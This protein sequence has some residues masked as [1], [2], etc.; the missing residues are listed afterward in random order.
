MITV[1]YDTSSGKILFP[2]SGSPA[3]GT[4]DASFVERFTAQVNDDLNTPRAL[5]V[6]WDLARSDLDE[7]DRKA[8]L[9]HFDDV[10]GLRLAAWAPVEEV[11]PD[12]ILALVAARQAA[13]KDS[14]RAVRKL[15]TVVDGRRV[16]RSDPPLIARLP[17]DSA[18][19]MAI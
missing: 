19:A 9:L 8:T 16:I 18:E 1:E 17:L 14:A 13:R 5:A 4:P 15:T 10:L 7:A 2:V 6:V 11:I 3:G 12:E